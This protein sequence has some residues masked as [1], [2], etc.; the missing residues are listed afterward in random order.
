[1]GEDSAPPSLFFGVGLMYTSSLVFQS[2]LVRIGVRDPQDIFL[3]RFTGPFFSGYKCLLRSRSS[4][5]F[6]QNQSYRDGY[7]P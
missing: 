4:E 6:C 7:T 1:M 2:Y 5:D 3:R